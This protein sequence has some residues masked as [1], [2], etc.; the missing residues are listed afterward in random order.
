[1]LCAEAARRYVK[2]YADERFVGV[3]VNSRLGSAEPFTVIWAKKYRKETVAPY[4]LSYSQ[5]NKL[6]SGC[7]EV[8]GRTEY[9]PFLKMKLL[10]Y[11]VIRIEVVP[12]CESEK[13]KKEILEE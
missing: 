3:D 10:Y 9:G 1:M 5:L 12:D 4:H 11:R 2:L 6:E 13:I 7:G 8:Y